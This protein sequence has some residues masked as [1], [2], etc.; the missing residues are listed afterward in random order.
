MPTTAATHPRRL[1]A[2]REARSPTLAAIRRHMRLESFSIT[3]YRSI[4]NAS[5]VQLSD[6]SILIG[7][8]N[9]GKSNVIRA[10]SVA[11]SAI[12]VAAGNRRVHGVS[13][14]R[15]FASSYSWERDFPISLQ[16]RKKSLESIFRVEFMLTH[17]EIADFKKEIGASINGHLTFEVRIGKERRTRVAIKKQGSVSLNQRLSDISTFV[18]KR[19]IF[20]YIPP[21]RTE[22]EA[23]SVI[24]NL[25]SSRLH[26]LDYAPDYIKALDQIKRLQKPIL[27][28]VSLEIKSILAEFIP[29]VNDVSIEVQE[30]RRQ[31]D[32]RGHMDFF[33]DD[34]NKT[35]LAF[36]GE[37][38]KSLAAI[39]ILKNGAFN[40]PRQSIIAIEEPESHL[41]PGAIRI[42]RDTIYSLADRSQVIVTTHNPLF[43]DRLRLRSNII[44]DG[45]KAKSAKSIKE[46]REL[47]GIQY[48]DNLVNARNILLVEGREDYM[49]VRSLLEYYSVPI[50]QALRANTLI[51][52]P[53]QGTGNLGYEVSHL[54]DS[55]C[56]VH[57]LLDHDKAGVEAFEKADA[58]GQL[59][60]R[61][62]TFVNCKGMVE[63]EFE[64]LI[65]PSVYREDIKSEL[66]VDI[67]LNIF[68]GSS[69]WATRMKAGFEKMGKTWSST[70]ESKAKF[71]V[72]QNVAQNPE[73][74]VLGGKKNIV[75]V[76]VK[77]VEELITLSTEQQKSA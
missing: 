4:T 61:D 13:R 25:L 1:I 27:N 51:I 42:L 55:L 45:G 53:M 30:G 67:M 20:D 31:Y 8:N 33:V 28:E 73:S 32:L 26:V 76:L 16:S 34:G 36:K 6:T 15:S 58:F 24:N 39:A 40:D 48:S 7:K 74:A 77:N 52:K 10:L 9:E 2:R 66:G 22:R 60:L 44:V 3:N 63:S 5:R 29:S 65:D 14:T 46:I 12:G 69:K 21:I 75:S 71:I 43:V 41:H 11:M 64:D 17:D 19:V 59:N 37:G 70:I 54:R 38:V 68:K 72:A 18:G 56:A 49:A 57:V 62:V 47:L 50:R 35:N 23:E